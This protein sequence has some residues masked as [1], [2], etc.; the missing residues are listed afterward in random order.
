MNGPKFGK[1]AKDLGVTAAFVRRCI[2]A[3]KYSGSRISERFLA[4]SQD[5]NELYYGDSWFAGVKAAL[6]ALEEGV[7]FFGPVK[8]S[9]AG[10]PKEEMEEIMKDAPSG[11]HIVFEC[12]EHQLFAVAYRYSLRSKGKCDLGDTCIL[13]RFD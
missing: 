3:T 4:K 11:S 9:T 10:F 13:P 1:H 12:E 7:E 8:T 5:L 2:E 6:T